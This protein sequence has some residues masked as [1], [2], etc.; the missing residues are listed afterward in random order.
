MMMYPY[1]VWSSIVEA[2]QHGGRELSFAYYACCALL[3]VLQGLQC[4]WFKLLC[5]AIW[6]VLTKGAAEDNR[7]D[8]DSDGD[9]EPHPR[10][11]LRVSPKKAQDLNCLK[12]D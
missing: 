5:K 3:L 6:G 1:V 8:S 11:P 4:F 10:S 12:D 9:E 7:S 2:P